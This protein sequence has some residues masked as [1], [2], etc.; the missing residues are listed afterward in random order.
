[1]TTLCIATKNVLQLFRY[2]GFGA[3]ALVPLQSGKQYRDIT[4]TASTL[5]IVQSS[6][7]DFAN[8]EESRVNFNDSGFWR[9]ES[10]VI[11]DHVIAGID[12]TALVP[13]ERRDLIWQQQFS[14]YGDV[15]QWVISYFNTVRS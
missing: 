5:S 14:V 1:M 8:T 12:Y 6:S 2:E 7:Y 3:I 15:F 13:T 10:S 11:P 4:V 9:L